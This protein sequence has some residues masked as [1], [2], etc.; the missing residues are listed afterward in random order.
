MEKIKVGISIGDLNGI[1]P[2]VVIKTFMDERILKWCIPIIY[3]SSKVVSYHKNI[4]NNE[5]TFHPLRIG[6][7]P[8]EGV[9]NVAN[10]W[11][12]NIIIT[13]GSPT[14]ESGK[15]S[16]LS[17]ETAVNDLKSGKIDALVTAPV[18]KEAL[19]ISGFPFPGHTEYLQH[20]MGIKH[21]LMFMVSS[22]IRVGLV[23]NHLPLEDVAANLSKELIE[24]KF[25]IMEQSLKVDF[26]IS[27]PK[28]A[29]L[30]LNP[31]AGDGGALGEEEKRI[32]YPAIASLRSTGKLVRGPFSADGFF[33]SGDFKK[34]DGVL[35]MY[36]D[37]G[38]IPF[39]LL[40]FGSGTNFTA[41]LSVIR[42]SPD[43]GTGYDIAGKNEADPS[44]FRT[45]I[46]MA[47]DLAK[48]RKEYAVDHANP[49]TRKN[50]Y[51][52]MEDEILSDIDELN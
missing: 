47:I 34:F 44:S 50:R 9:V 46:Y 7:N 6:E 29:V 22:E 42:T 19:K 43:H 11:S 8:K 4:V 27:K 13:L 2:E 39:K 30:G 24:T 18:N 26:G 12:E 5:F 15:Y 23:T 25:H 14:E 20:A 41:G 21:S 49:L 40:S 37:Q 16:I 28:I 52:G 33:G 32:I 45:A 51:E 35:A 38:M 10:C 31:H 36:H 17:F 1:G 48:N 3:A